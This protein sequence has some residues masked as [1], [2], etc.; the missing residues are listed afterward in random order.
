[1]RHPKDIAGRII[2]KLETLGYEVEEE[3]FDRMVG[4][5]GI[6]LEVANNTAKK[7]PLDRPPVSSIDED[8]KCMSDYFPGEFYGAP[9][10]KRFEEMGRQRRQ[11]WL[12]EILLK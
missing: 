2:S 10:K 12:N 9:A 1:M 11:R 6:A 8:R 7:D 3:D 4:F 5:G